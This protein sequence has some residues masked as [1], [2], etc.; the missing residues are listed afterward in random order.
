M[1]IKQDEEMRIEQG[2]ITIVY[3][4][5]PDITRAEKVFRERTITSPE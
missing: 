5:L 2:D 4:S 3:G 1:V